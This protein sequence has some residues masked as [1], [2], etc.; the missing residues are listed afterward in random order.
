RGRV[1][2]T[3]RA[4]PMSVVFVEG[5][6]VEAAVTV[7]S[8]ARWAGEH[9]REDTRQIGGQRENEKIRE[10]LPALTRDGPIGA[11][12]R[13]GLV[14]ISDRSGHLRGLRLHDLMLQLLQTF[15]VQVESLLIFAAQASAKSL[16]VFGDG[17]ENQAAVQKLGIGWFGRA[18]GV[19]KLQELL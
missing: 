14:G 10:R 6:G 15:E 4:Q 16:G 2:Q 3:F 17:V 8:V 1:H 18:A 12:A 19:G 5:G 7:V 13:I 11:S 9:V